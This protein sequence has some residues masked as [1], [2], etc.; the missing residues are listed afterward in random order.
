MNVDVVI[1]ARESLAMLFRKSTVAAHE[2][3]ISYHRLISL[4]RSEKLSR[5]QKDSSGDYVWTEQDLAAAR[6]ALAVDRRRKQ[7]PS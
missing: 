3:G 5:P 6:Q 1:V 4:L 2:L 7:V